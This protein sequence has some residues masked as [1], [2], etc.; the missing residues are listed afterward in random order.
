MADG[1]VRFIDD[2]IER[3]SLAAEKTT[4]GSGSSPYGVWGALGS[5]ADGESFTVDF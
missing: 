3:G 4:V 2:N 1:A 5:R